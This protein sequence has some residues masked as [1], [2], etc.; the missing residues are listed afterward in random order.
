MHHVITLSCC[1]NQYA[2]DTAAELPA[3]LMTGLAIR[4]LPGG[5][6]ESFQGGTGRPWRSLA[7]L[8]SEVAAHISAAAVALGHGLAN[9][10]AQ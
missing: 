8:L 1:T 5:A 3:D 7:A 2:I 10:T 6:V 4:G 9:L